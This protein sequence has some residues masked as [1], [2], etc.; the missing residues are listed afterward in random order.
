MYLEKR[1]KVMTDRQNNA[2]PGLDDAQFLVLAG[3][4]EQWTVAVERHAVDHVCVAIYHLHRL[5]FADVPYEDLQSKIW[6]GD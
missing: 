6:Y 4:S 2:S 1:S 3:G 5:A